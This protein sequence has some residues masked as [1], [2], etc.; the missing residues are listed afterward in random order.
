MRLIAPFDWRVA[1]IQERF[2]LS[3]LAAKKQV[4]E[5]D[6]KRKNFMSFFKGGDKPQSELFD[7]ILNRSKM[8][9][10]EIVKLII[11]LAKARQMA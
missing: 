3:E 9:E 6:E 10:D 11:A 8:S 1:R 7:L 5:N 4:I 2:K